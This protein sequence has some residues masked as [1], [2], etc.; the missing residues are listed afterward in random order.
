MSPVLVDSLV[1]I[2]FFNGRATPA[3][4]K[5]RGYLGVRSMVIGD[6]ILME[7]LQGFRYAADVRRAERLFEPFTCLVLGSQA[8]AR[9]AAMNYRQLRRLGVTP[10]SSLDVL[11]ATFCVQRDHPLLASD[12]D[13]ERMAAPLGLV[14]L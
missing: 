8:M 9:H 10:R 2:D 14:L 12:R 1:W 4:E 13:F 5:L 11:I 3:T 6:L 7:V